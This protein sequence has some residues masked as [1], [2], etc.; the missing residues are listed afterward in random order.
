MTDIHHV[1]SNAHLIHARHLEQ[2]VIGACLMDKLA[3]AVARRHL[4]PDD[5]TEPAWRVAFTA[6]CALHDASRHVDPTSVYAE[7]TRGGKDVALTQTLLYE[8]ATTTDPFNTSLEELASQVADAS[9]DR[10]LHSQVM[11]ILLTAHNDEHGALAARVAAV[12]STSQ[13]KDAA[14]VHIADVLDEIETTD[15]NDTVLPTGKPSLD[16]VL[17]GGLC[18]GVTVL[19]G[20]PG[21]GKSALAADIAL[22]VAMQDVGQVL[23]FCM[24]MRNRKTV[25][26]MLSQASGILAHRIKHDAMSPNE[27]D[28]RNA[29]KRRMRALPMR[30]MD[31]GTLTTRRIHDEVVAAQVAGPVALVVVDYLQQLAPQ[32]KRQSKYQAVSAN[33]NSILRMSLDLRVPVL[34]LAQVGRD[35]EKERT[36]PRKSDLRDSGEI[37]QD[38]ECIM[39]VWQ[40]YV[41]GLSTDPSEAMIIIDKQRN[42][43]PVAKIPMRWD[44]ARTAYLD[45][46]A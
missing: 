13:R 3:P 22:S 45:P 16:R 11:Q 30:M 40:P 5:F 37:E 43:V 44:G 42:G 15:D 20:R 34:L 27:R 36:P 39:F 9:R 24:E 31:A 33:S 12:C 14:L 32:D 23:Y 41:V 21:M 17:G 18:S 1:E 10:R 25:Q 4:T 29:T 35:A 26:R 46:E 2:H 6:I 19:G 7:A 8:A 38:A 28:R